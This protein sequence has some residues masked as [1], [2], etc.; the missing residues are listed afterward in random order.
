MLQILSRLFP[1]IGFLML[2]TLA[3]I[4]ACGSDE[5]TDTLVDSSTSARATPQPKATV[6][7]DGR[8][9]SK[10]QPTGTGQ[11]TT[12]TAGAASEDLAAL[13]AMYE[14][15][16][17]R[18]TWA[19]DAKSI[20]EVPPHEM[21]GVIPDENGR[22]IGL[23]LSNS[24]FSGEIPP[25]LGRLTVLEWLDLSANQLSGEIPT[26]LGNL[27][28]LEG[29]YLGHN[30][31]VGDIPAE[32]GDLTSLRQLSLGSNQLTGEIPRELGNLV[33]FEELD[34]Q[35]N[36]LNGELPKELGNLTAL[37]RLDL[38]YNQLTGDLPAELGRLGN[39]QWLDLRG[40]DFTL[41]PEELRKL[42]VQNNLEINDIYVRVS[43]TVPYSDVEQLDANDTGLPGLLGKATECRRGLR[44]P[45]DSFWVGGV[46]YILAH[47]VD[48]RM[49]V[50]DLLW[51]ESDSPATVD[52]LFRALDKG[53]IPGFVASSGLSVN[54]SSPYGN[55]TFE[56]IN[57]PTTQ[58]A[59]SRQIVITSHSYDFDLLSNAVSDGEPEKLRSLLAGEN[60]D[61]NAI[62]GDRYSILSKAIDQGN[63]E[64][65]KVLTE[66]GA[67]VNRRDKDGS[68]LIESAIRDGD[69]DLVRILVDAGA[70]V[71]ASDALW[72]AVEGGNTEVVR[73]L[74]DAG[75]DVNPSDPWNR[76]SMGHSLLDMA[77]WIGNPEI[78]QILADAG[79]KA[80]D[81]ITVVDKGQPSAADEWSYPNTAAGLYDAVADGDVQVV[82]N[83]V[84]A[85][86]DVNAKAAGGESILTN[87]VILGFPEIVRVLVDAGAD[88][89]AIDNF[90]GSVLY[91]A[92][93]FEPDP[94]IVQ[95]L[96]DSGADVNFKGPFGDS[97]LVEARHG[98]NPEVI[99]ILID[100]GAVE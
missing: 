5:A 93:G 74:V 77:N 98:G 83:L 25:E 65:V 53:E 12:P 92:V 54:F 80:T 71:D 56:Q 23:F 35:D 57:T 63:I 61:V 33:N 85:G 50:R 95:M 36:Q 7:S 14:A 37:Q 10:P 29:L 15:F 18:P 88:V 59:P 42:S 73:L 76:G 34:L 24:L 28:N 87:A 90:G 100:A 46:R 97:V 32:L 62:S 30:L 69:V 41:M 44:F 22:V 38:S 31:F 2:A 58:N 75:A 79:A 8:D 40:N 78:I 68:P 17:E 96:V 52:S 6:A 9:P 3:L 99:G 60:I 20:L 43:I 64:M 91:G 11:Q 27:V 45:E 16:G 89:N 13:V 1:L 94:A 72:I 19:D 51:Q 66:L 49:V 39:L 70:D 81:G 4:M 86:V 82:Q 84:D 26:E 21:I 48:G 67:D 47:G 55:F